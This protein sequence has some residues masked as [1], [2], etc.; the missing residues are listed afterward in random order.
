LPKFKQ[1]AAL[2]AFHHVAVTAD[3]VRRGVHARFICDCAAAVAVYSLWAQLA[4]G[5]CIRR[6]RECWPPMAW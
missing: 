5:V 3:V 1:A 4:A 2:A 6:R